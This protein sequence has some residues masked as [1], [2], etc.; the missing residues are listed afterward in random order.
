MYNGKRKFLSN[1]VISDTLLC[2][3]RFRVSHLQMPNTNIA[4]INVQ[5]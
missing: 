2:S 5:A 3:D 1:Y 4:A